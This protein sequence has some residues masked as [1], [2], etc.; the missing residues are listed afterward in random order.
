[1][2]LNFDRLTMT[3][4]ADLPITTSS[5]GIVIIIDVTEFFLNHCDI[6]S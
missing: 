1:M 4:V 3:T 2:K 5:S 6:F